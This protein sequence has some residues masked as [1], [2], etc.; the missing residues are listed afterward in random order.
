MTDQL[1]QLFR[2][3]AIRL[4]VFTSL[5]VAMLS[6]INDV[7]LLQLLI[8]AGVSFGVMYLLL[9]GTITLFIRT[10]IQIPEVKPLD[11]KIEQGEIIDF[12]VGDVPK[13]LQ[14]K[15][16]QFPG[17]IDQNLSSGLPDSEQQAEIVRR[18]GWN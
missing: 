13:N 4:T 10:A 16:S 12:T 2:V 3:W 18:M 8:R 14:G 6:W 17:Q 15:E 1:S 7:K 5:I 11:S 9:V